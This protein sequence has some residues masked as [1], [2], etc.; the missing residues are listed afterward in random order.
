MTIAEEIA[1]LRA[2]VA[3]LEA[4]LDA[5]EAPPA[6]A[7]SA[8]QS[9]IE[10]GARVFYPPPISSFVMPD[11]PDLHSLLRCV[12]LRFP[13]LKNA[14]GLV[15]RGDTESNE[16]EYFRMFRASFKALGSFH[17]APAPDRKHYVQHWLD[18][19]EDWLKA[20]G[21]FTPIG[22]YPFISAAL[23]HGDIP[24]CGLFTDGEVLT[25]GL[26][27]YRMGNAPGDAWRH[28]IS[29]GRI[30]PPVPSPASQAYPMP[31]IRIVEG[32]A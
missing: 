27:A 29:T 5:K 7:K 10:E 19:A 1:A 26:N 12:F 32:A 23:A 2:Q 9:I 30:L 16:R 20:V 6:P 21:D 24:Y 15:F 22:G 14:D 18:L 31:P 17:R 11:D 28:V 13:R 25:L 3:K 4:R 8:P